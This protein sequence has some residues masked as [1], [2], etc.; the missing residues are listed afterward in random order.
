MF[1]PNKAEQSAPSESGSDSVAGTPSEDWVRAAVEEGVLHNASGIEA[2]LAAAKADTPLEP[3][4][5]REF[6]DHPDLLAKLRR[7]LKDVSTDRLSEKQT[8]ANVAATQIGGRRKRSKCTGSDTQASK[9][10]DSDSA[11]ASKR[12]ASPRQSSHAE[13]QADPTSRDRNENAEN[14]S[15]WANSLE[16]QVGGSVPAGWQRYRLENEIGRGGCGVV[17]RARDL[18]LERDVVLKRIIEDY[19]ESEEIVQRFLNEARITGGLEHPGVVPVHEIGVDNTGSPFFAMKEVRGVTLSEKIRELHSENRRQEFR[20]QQK[21][22]LDRFLS[23]CQTMAFAHAADVIHR[24]L[25]PANVMVGEFGETLVLDW[26]LARSLAQANNE[27]TLPSRKS[28]PKRKGFKQGTSAKGQARSS[29]PQ[30]VDPD[31][32]AISGIAPERSGS[33]LRKRESNPMMTRQGTVLGTAAYMSPEQASGANDRVNQQSDVFSLGV[34]LYEILSGESP[35]RSDTVQDTIARVAECKYEPLSKRVSKVSKPLAAICTHAMNRRQSDRYHDAGELAKDVERYLSGGRISV[36]RE[37]LWERFDRTANNHRAVFRAAFASCVLLAT[38][39]V[40][41]AAKI[42]HANLLERMATQAA[43]SARAEAEDARDKERSAREFSERQLR[44]SREAADEWLIQLSGD[45]QFYPGMQPVRADL[46]EKGIE[47]YLAII[48]STEEQIA[49]N[50]SRALEEEQLRSH[51]RLA[52]L[53][54]LQGQLDGALDHYN[55][56]ESIADGLLNS[57]DTRSV[58]AQPGKNTANAVIIREREPS[59]PLRRTVEWKTQ[60]ANAVLGQQLVLLQKSDSISDPDEQHRSRS[61]V[62]RTLLHQVDLLEELVNQIPDAIEPRNALARVLLVAGRIA[63]RKDPLSDSGEALVSSTQLIADALV[64]AELACHLSPEQR[65]QTLRNT[66]LE[67]QARTLFRSQNTNNA[68]D[69]CQ[70][71]IRELKKQ[72]EAEPD[73]PDRLETQS[74]A[75]MLAGANAIRLAD[76]ADALHSFDDAQQDLDHAWNLL[77][78]ENFYRQNQAI[79]EINRASAYVGLHRFDEAYDSLQSAVGD[80]RLLLQVDGVTTRRIEQLVGCYLKLL[81]VLEHSVEDQH[82]V[83]RE[84]L[85]RNTRTLIDHLTDASPEDASIL[86]SHLRY[87][88]ALDQVPPRRANEPAISASEIIPVDLLNLLDE[89]ETSMDT[90]DSSSPLLYGRAVNTLLKSSCPINGDK[91]PSDSSARELL[92]R[93]ERSCEYLRQITVVG[94]RANQDAAYG[95]LAELHCLVLEKEVDSKRELQLHDLVR[96]WLESHPESTAANHW[97][98][99][100]Q[101]QE[102][103]SSEAEISARRAIQLRGRAVPEDRVLLDLIRNRNHHWTPPNRPNATQEPPQLEASHVQYLRRLGIRTT[104]GEATTEQLP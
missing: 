2:L 80:I 65:H 9:A 17:T 5:E 63:V 98:G 33:G 89:L 15:D 97:L 47:H 32:T 25:K 48:A 69:A 35:F 12:L 52:D 99:I 64:H 91:Q 85:I 29:S 93:V 88:E 67:T 36:Y 3:I 95:L 62:R 94:N 39:A 49:K 58:R 41:A 8:L 45:L 22:L 92:T 42:G 30:P 21:R 11:V 100:I 18:Q 66:I 96:Q 82:Q 104:I 13:I 83:D 71:W 37:R 59:A 28:S 101:L 87:H 31:A 24:D 76:F 40:V 57:S 72:S 6:A 20:L 51:L 14:R 68:A 79:L 102:G 73:R 27:A 23:V 19:S 60:K 61:S 44:N 74:Q 54:R 84:E 75:S 86:D 53:L 1:S 90:D 55:N 70:R 81:D 34:M 78:G 43:V 16:S 56:A 50:S 103:L 7:C 38:G 46:I 26:G 77:Y 4:L 10:K